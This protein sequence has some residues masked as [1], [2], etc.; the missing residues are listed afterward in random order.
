MQTCRRP[1][2]QNP[3]TPA[4]S[5]ATHRHGCCRSAGRTSPTGSHRQAPSTGAEDIDLP[6]SPDTDPFEGAS[7][8]LADARTRRLRHRGG[9]RNSRAGADALEVMTPGGQRRKSG[10]GRAVPRR[11]R[12]RGSMPDPCFGVL[13]RCPKE[14]GAT[15]PAPSTTR[16]Q[17]KGRRKAKF[18]VESLRPSTTSRLIIPTIPAGRCPAAL[19]HRRL[20]ERTRASA[21]RSQ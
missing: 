20:R 10:V 17:T 8:R 3:R 11:R 13:R 14:E 18:A 7:G 1:R 4:W 9:R 16:A 15:R 19:G 6:R 21:S 2:R 5:T 12:D